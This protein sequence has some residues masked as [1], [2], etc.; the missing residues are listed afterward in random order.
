MNEDSDSATNTE[1]VAEAQAVAA[2]VRKA[3][4][5]A[6]IGQRD[7]I[8]QILVALFAAGHVLV[9]GVPGLGR[10][11]SRARSPAPLAVTSVAS[12]SHLT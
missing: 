5:H 12:S 2:R 1:M 4:G 11:C 8:D 10:R 9:E 3:I 7:V 6:V